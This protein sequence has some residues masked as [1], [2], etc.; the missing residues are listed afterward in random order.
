MRGNFGGDEYV[1]GDSWMGT[2]ICLIYPTVYIKY[3]RFFIY[4]LYLN[5]AV[6]FNK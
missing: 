5:K 2:F 3:V 6:K 1:C 4:Q